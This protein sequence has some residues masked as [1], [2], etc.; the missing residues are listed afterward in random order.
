MALGMFSDACDRVLLLDVAADQKTMTYSQVQL[1]NLSA[2][3]AGMA[4]GAAREGGAARV[5]PRGACPEPGDGCLH[6]PRV[7]ASSEGR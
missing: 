2:D 3:G 1:S 5:C 6:G 4:C 7:G